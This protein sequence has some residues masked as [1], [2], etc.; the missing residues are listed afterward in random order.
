[1]QPNHLIGIFARDVIQSRLRLQ[2]RLRAAGEG[3]NLIL[4]T[5]L[6]ISFR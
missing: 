2:T 1:M 4:I 6:R 3:K 5:F